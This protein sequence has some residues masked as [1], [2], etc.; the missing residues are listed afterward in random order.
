MKI[1]KIGF[2]ILIST[3]ILIAP[4]ARATTWMDA[5]SAIKI[6]EKSETEPIGNINSNYGQ[7]L[8]MRIEL[9][10]SIYHEFFK[11]GL[12]TQIITTSK[13]KTIDPTIIQHIN[14]IDQTHLQE[15]D[16]KIPLD[17]EKEGRAG[18]TNIC[19]SFIIRTTFEANSVG[20]DVTGKYEKERKVVVCR[21][22]L[23]TPTPSPS[24]VVEPLSTLTPSA[25]AEPSPEPSGSPTTSTTTSFNTD[26]DFNSSG[27]G[28][29]AACSKT[30]LGK[31]IKAIV[32]AIPVVGM[33]PIAFSLFSIS[34]AIFVT[35]RR[36]PEHWVKVID[37]VTGKPV[38]GAIINIFSPDGKVRAT[39][40]SDSKTGNA[41]DLLQQGEY[42]FVVQKPGY[43]FPSVEEPMFAMQSGEFIYRSG[44]INFK[45][46]NMN[47]NG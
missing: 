47:L 37:A 28:A 34:S 29:I 41:G 45:R 35:D 2:G 6:L 3:A 39:W 17:F 8:N 1:G 13:D 16:V 7:I 15:F 22:I 44:L 9:N 23:A 25:T 11:S 4:Q 38:G 12:R 40:I 19:S 26:D 32:M 21:D 31:G 42:K 18:G 36:R 33:I 24:P 30:I 43:I 10:E 5:F 46:S 14:P 20:Y 27:S